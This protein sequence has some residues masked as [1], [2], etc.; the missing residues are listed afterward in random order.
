MLAKASFFNLDLQLS[1]MNTSLPLYLHCLISEPSSFIYR[2]FIITT[3]FLV[4]PI[5]ILI[6]Q[7]GLQEWRKKGSTFMEVTLSH[8]DCFTYNIVIMDLL[9]VFGSIFGLH[10]IIVNNLNMLFWAF[11][12]YS[13]CWF[14]LIFFHMLTCV[15]HYMA[16]VHPITYLSLRKERGVRIRIIS[17]G[18][19]WL[20]CFAIAGFIII[21][22]IIISIVN[23]CLL[24]LSLTVSSF[25][26]L[27]VLRVLIHSGPREE[28]RNRDRVDQ[29]KKRAFYTIVT[30]LGMLALKF[31]WDLNWSVVYIT[32]GLN[33]CMLM[34]W[35]VWF[36]LPSNLLLPLLFLHR[37]GKVLCCKNN[38][39]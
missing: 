4:L 34:S 37:K 35:G 24:T 7:H 18:C 17:I 30:I 28:S 20:L 3:I 5:C 1:S 12:L 11:F 33:G 29:S 31:C 16:A 8:S 36:N 22:D 19:V 25:C 26:S 21:E 39:Q 14:G 9:A 10:S 38:M 15:E 6:L 27:S 13:V 2:A 23:F 32:G